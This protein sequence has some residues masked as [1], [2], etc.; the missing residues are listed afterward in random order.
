MVSW[1]LWMY[2]YSYIWLLSMFTVYRFLYHWSRKQLINSK[3][4][5]S[6]PSIAPSQGHDPYQSSFLFVIILIIIIIITAL[7][8]RV[9]NLLQCP[10]HSSLSESPTI[11]QMISESSYTPGITAPPEAL[12]HQIEVVSSSNGQL[13]KND[14]ENCNKLQASLIHHKTGRSSPTEWQ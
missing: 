9:E 13:D 8:S 11:H 14:S 2:L 5:N 12:L 1:E 6:S 10:N 7:S 4:N 3:Q